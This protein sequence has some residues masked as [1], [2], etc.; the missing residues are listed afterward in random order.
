M[1]PAPKNSTELSPER[2][3]RPWVIGIACA[4]SLALFGVWFARRRPI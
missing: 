2:E 4:L 1:V 3:L